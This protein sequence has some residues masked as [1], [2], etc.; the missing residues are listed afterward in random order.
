MLQRRD[1]DLPVAP[2]NAVAALVAA[3]FGFAIA[4]H[5]QVS[6]YDVG[7]LAV[8]GITTI[9]IAF[10]MFMEGAKHVPPAEASLIAMLDVVMG[11]LW[12]LLAFGERP[13]LAT[14]IGG[15]IVLAAAVWRLAPE[16][17]TANGVLRA[18]RSNSIVG[19]GDRTPVRKRVQ[20]W[21]RR[22]SRW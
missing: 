17:E 2:I 10:A 15:G 13:D 8:F 1:P 14:L 21:S 11:P 3:G 18:S 7:V 5:V 4:G 19:G 22:N 16:I 9:T 12:V 6:W 20:G